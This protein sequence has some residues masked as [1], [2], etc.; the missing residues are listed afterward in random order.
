M[1]NHVVTHGEP[2]G[3]TWQAMCVTHG[4]PCV[5]M[6]GSF[7]AYIRGFIWAVGR[8]KESSNSVRGGSSKE[9]E[10]E[11]KREGGGKEKRKGGKERRKGGKE[12]KRKEEKRR[13][14]GRK[15]GKR[16]RKRKE[17]YAVSRPGRQ[18]TRNCATRGRFPLT[19]IILHLGAG[20]G[21]RLSFGFSGEFVC[22]VVCL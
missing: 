17:C 18:R 21:L 16:K 7:E 11:G 3:D 15:R 8:S 19:L 4:M 22:C 1:V 13:R 5:N 12:K 10:E 2:C 6:H 9:K 20:N 14:K